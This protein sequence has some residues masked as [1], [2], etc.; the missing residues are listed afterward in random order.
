MI[1]V[2]AATPYPELKV[3]G[4]NS[5]YA[6]I[7]TCDLASSTGEM[8][9]VYQYLYQHWILD[10]NDSDITQTLVRIAEVEMR[11]LDM[12]GRLIEML[13]GNPKCEAIHGY[14]RFFWQGSMVN[15]N[16]QLPVLL[17]SNIYLERSAVH[18]YLEQADFIE[19]H[20]VSAVLARIAEDEEIHY[21]IFQDFLA[22]YIKTTQ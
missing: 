15:Y 18:D 20:Y 3:E 4:R 10:E 2:S 6:H 19:D 11:H 22:D 5:H 8:T 21:A 1:P 12:L 7:L 14:K 17:K 9:A 16:Q 13:G